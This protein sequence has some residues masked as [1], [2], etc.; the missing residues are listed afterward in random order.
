MSYES[1]IQRLLLELK[2]GVIESKPKSSKG[3]ILTTHAGYANRGDG[4]VR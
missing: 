3:Y 4:E 2:G 1:K